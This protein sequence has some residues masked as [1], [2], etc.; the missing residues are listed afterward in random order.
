MLSECELES[1][2]RQSSVGDE[3]LCSNACA[4]ENF[5]QIEAEK[6]ATVSDYPTD[7]WINRDYEFVC[8]VDKVCCRL[9]DTVPDNTCFATDEDDGVASTA[10][11]A[12]AVAGSGAVV[13]ALVLFGLYYRKKKTSGE[14][15]TKEIEATTQDGPESTD[16]QDDTATASFTGTNITEDESVIVANATLVPQTHDLDYKSQWDETPVAPV[17]PVGRERNSSPNSRDPIGIKKNVEL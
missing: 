1:Y 7:L 13:V 17:T 5:V 14:D 11:I 10:V 9:G 4:A 16:Q 6:C 12:G 8:F 15:A 3:A 2:R